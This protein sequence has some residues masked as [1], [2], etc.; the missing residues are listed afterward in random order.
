MQKMI[1]V[2]MLSGGWN[3]LKAKILK[4]W[5]FGKFTCEIFDSNDG[6]VKWLTY[7]KKFEKYISLPPKSLVVFARHGI[8]SP[9]VCITPIMNVAREKSMYC[10]I[11]TCEFKK[12]NFRRPIRKWVGFPNTFYRTIT[13]PITPCFMSCK[14]RGFRMK[15]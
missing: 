6:C 15:L 4:N 5:L 10:I 9:I 2:V 1:Y 3:L 7:Q 12:F 14:M 13:R 11:I 8:A